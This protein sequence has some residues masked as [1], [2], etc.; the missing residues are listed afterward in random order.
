VHP[1][2]SNEHE[3]R[4]A[5]APEQAT[6]TDLNVRLAAQELHITWAD[7]RQSVFPLAYLRRH[8][9]CAACRTE[10]EKQADNPLKILSHKPIENLRVTDAAL[11]GNYAIR[12]DWSDHHNTGI[13]DF[14]YLRWLDDAR[15]A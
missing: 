15:P 13:Y 12:F 4:E 5:L 6:P 10:R 11:C 8:C 3:A 14:R 9:P 1:P 7:G 2:T